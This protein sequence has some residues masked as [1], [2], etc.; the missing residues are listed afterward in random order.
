M[1]NTSI[2]NLSQKIDPAT[3]EVL[4]TVSR[5]C[6]DLGVPWVV[7]GAT[8]RDLVLHHGYGAKVK[9]ATHDIDF[10]IEV[11]NWETFERI[12]QQLVD[13]GF[14]ESKSQHRMYGPNDETVDLIPFGQIENEGSIIEWPPKGEV[15]MNVLGFSEA[16]DYAEKVIICDE[17]NLIIPVATPV[18]LVLLKLISWTDRS[19]DIRRKDATDIKY[20][21]ENYEIIP[22]VTD[23]VYDQHNTEVMERYGWDLTLASAQLL[24]KHARRIATE[25]TTRIINALISSELEK[26]DLETLIIEMSHNTIEEERDMQLT[27]AFV[28]GFQE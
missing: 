18:G 13:Q 16:C 11:A 19:P 22:S 7:V 14:N 1:V 9:R 2:V 23:E 24:G 15:A 28:A 25:D 20:I 8:A 3:V 4:R 5:I 27:N 12:K 17:S 26:R 10:A 6:T 21:L